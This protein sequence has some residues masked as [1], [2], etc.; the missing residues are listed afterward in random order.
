MQF[1]LTLDPELSFVSEPGFTKG[2]ASP[3]LEMQRSSDL[4]KDDA[5]GMWHLKPNYL[6]ILTDTDVWKLSDFEYVTD[7]WYE[8]KRGGGVRDPDASR[9]GFT[10]LSIA[11]PSSA[12]RSGIALP[13][14][15]A[16]YAWPYPSGTN[17]DASY[18]V[19]RSKQLIAEDQGVCFL[20]EAHNDGA[21]ASTNFF[22][23]SWDRITVTISKGK[24]LTVYERMFGADPITTYGSM[25]GYVDVSSVWNATSDTLTIAVTPIPGRGISV[26]VGSIQSTM[27]TLSGNY[28]TVASTSKLIPFR[29]QTEYPSSYKLL[30]AGFLYIRINPFASL[31]LAVA[32]ITYV[33]NG[34]GVT[35]P[36]SLPYPPSVS[37][38]GT[39]RI[40]G[41]VPHA[42]ENAVSTTVAV[43]NHD[44][45]GDWSPGS[46]SATASV[47]MSTTNAR[48]TPFLHS[49]GVQWPRVTT[50]RAPGSVT[51]PGS[52][53]LSLEYTDDI[54]ARGSGRCEVLATK[55]STA[56]EKLKRGDV[57]YQLDFRAD[58]SGSWQPYDFG[59][60][61]NTRLEPHAPYRGSTDY[62]KASFDMTGMH[63]RLA[64]VNVTEETGFDGLSIGDAI[65]RVLQGAGFEQITDL[66]LKARV[67]KLPL[68]AGEERWKWAPAQGQSGL[69]VIDVLLQHLDDAV[70]RYRL[71]FSPDKVWVLEKIPFGTTPSY[72]WLRAAGASGL[73]ALSFQASP[74]P[75]E[76]NLVVMQGATSS[77]NEG[78]RL[79][80]YISNDESVTNPNSMDYLGRR[81]IVVVL[82]PNI[83]SERE[84]NF[85]LK[86]FRERVMRGLV[87]VQVDISMNAPA[88]GVTAVPNCGDSVRFLDAED[89]LVFPHVFYAHRSTVSVTGVEQRVTYT[90]S[91]S[92]YDDGGS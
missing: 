67:T 48:Y 41:Y 84:L 54:M 64:E 59:I 15:I 44:G 69:E 57:Y 1:R 89:E 83:Q 26:K 7:Y 58:D 3:E 50:T 38:T 91:T 36:F 43:T 79:V 8:T 81:K 82:A 86:Q 78:E 87:R 35:A 53:I 10:F 47:S 33:G 21:F 37:P 11:K 61:A 85:W 75:P 18:W 31:N 80:K 71:R 66:P 32:P 72:V 30:S 49:F 65:N 9:P 28:R 2:F 73:W 90:F 51:I 16:N 22:G 56:L 14:G 5:T 63:A 60:I 92:K 74:Y 40:Y 19:L 45:T 42:G 20:L 12:S 88:P 76:A 34:S 52:S 77:A 68:A 29:Y 55:G 27:R 17:Q 6:G 39:D 62:Y 24:L 23:F 25:R 46:T 13:S 4:V 70:D